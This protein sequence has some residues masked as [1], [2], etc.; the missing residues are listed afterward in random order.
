MTRVVLY[1]RVSTEKQDREGASPRQQQ[2]ACEQYA[3][4]HDLQIVRVL[5]DVVSGR[6]ES[7]DRPG[8]NEALAMLKRGE[9]DG[10]LVWNLD[11]F[12][13]NLVDAL[14]L[15][16]DYFG[17]GQPHRLFSATEDVNYHTPEGRLTLHLKLSVAEYEADKTRQRI[18]AN[19]SYYASIGAYCGGPPPYGYKPSQRTRTRTRGGRR[20]PRR[21]EIDLDEQ[22]VIKR[23]HELAERESGC[24]RAIARALAE[25]GV[26]NRKRK[27]F[28]PT[29]IARILESRPRKAG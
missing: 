4:A 12:S 26:T 21:L 18:R 8:L 1:T 7:T 14:R 22:R 3:S 13:R 20:E 17:E 11:R 5:Q 23:I 25:E 24:L 27:I 9:A 10:V 28:H 2:A 15:A 16:R 6:K 29:Q 19:K